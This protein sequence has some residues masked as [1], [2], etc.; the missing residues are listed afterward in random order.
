MMYIFLGVHS[1]SP[2]FILVFWQVFSTAHGQ[3][4]GLERDN[5]RLQ[6][7]SAPLLTIRLWPRHNLASLNLRTMG[8]II[9]SWRVIV[10]VLELKYVQAFCTW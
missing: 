7:S 10:K 2:T 6:P 8:V 1:R 4:L 5:A 9:P 3:Y